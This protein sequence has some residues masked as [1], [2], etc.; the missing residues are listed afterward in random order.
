MSLS[1][2]QQNILQFIREFI[3]EHHFP[4]TIREIGEN[5]GISSTSVVNYNLNALEKKGFI[6]RDRNVSRGLRLSKPETARRPA[7]LGV[8]HVPLVGRIAA[9]EPV[10]AF[11]LD[12]ESAR[13]VRARLFR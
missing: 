12:A 8:V 13:C 7:M 5:V 10:P 11:G 1:F 9:G 2:R 4:P 3:A 6:V